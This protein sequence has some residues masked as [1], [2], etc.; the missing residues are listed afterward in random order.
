MKETLEYLEHF[1]NGIRTNNTFMILVFCWCFGFLLKKWR[2]FPND[3][4]PVFVIPIGAFISVIMDNHH[5]PELSLTQERIGNTIVGLV[6]STGAWVSHRLVWKNLS[7]IPVIGQYL[8]VEQ[9]DPK[10]FVKG[11][12]A[13][14]EEINK[15]ETK[16]D[17]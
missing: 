14:V 16:N 15:G 11:E 1:L 12:N 6:I 4:I 13:N 3:L 17:K 9:S 8:D 7:K 5:T 2:K 10:A